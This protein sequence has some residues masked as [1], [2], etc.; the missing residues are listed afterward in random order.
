[1]NNDQGTYSYFSGNISLK[2][3]EESFCVF[4]SLPAISEGQRPSI[5]LVKELKYTLFTRLS[6]E[7]G[8][9]K[10]VTVQLDP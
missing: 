7:K 2:R 10:R 5:T 6:S 3:S 1:M 9:L 4:S 8:H